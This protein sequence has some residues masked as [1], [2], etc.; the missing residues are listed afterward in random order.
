MI[1]ERAQPAGRQ[2][3]VHAGGEP[4]ERLDRVGDDDAGQRVVRPGGERGDGAGRGGGGQ[5][6]VRRRPAP[7]ATAT[8]RS[9]A[10]TV[11]ESR[12]TAPVTTR[13]GR[14]RSARRRSARADLGQ[15]QRD[16]ARRPQRRPRTSRSTA[17]SSKGCTVPRDL[18]AGL[19]ALAGDQQGVARAGQARRRRRARRAGRRPRAPR[20]GRPSGTSATPASIGGADGGGVL[21]ARVVVGHDQDIAAGGRSGPHRGPLAGIAVAAAAEH[22]DQ[23]AAR[24]RR[25]ARP[26]RWRR[27][28]GCA[29]SRRRRRTA[30]R[31][32][33]APSGR[34]R[35]SRRC[36]ASAVSTGTPTASSRATARTALATLKRPGS[37]TRAG[38][39]APPGP[40]SVKVE[41]PP[42]AGATSVADQSAGAGDRHGAGVRAQAGEP[43]AGVVVDVTTSRRGPAVEQQRLGLEVVLEVAVEVEVVAAEVG[44]ARRRRTGR[45]RPG[46]ARAR[47]WRPP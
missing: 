40:C 32:R 28:P 30:G 47:G 6:V 18:L 22:G 26:A 29:R 43:A 38:Q 10:A 21:G 42:G 36:P 27:R 17:R 31:R 35:R 37:R 46:P 33:P 41:P 25:A 24:G 3:G 9:P 34:G 23:P 1:A 14:R 12:V 5:E 19:V 8:N 39:V 13:V 45:R 4:A 20:P 15:G 2:P 16:H 44:E 7:P 11:R